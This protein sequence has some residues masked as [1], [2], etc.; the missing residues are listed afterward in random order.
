MACL[1]AV[2]TC[3]RTP[4]E[5]QAAPA[6][7]SEPPE[8]QKEAPVGPKQVSV[9]TEPPPRRQHDDGSLQNSCITGL[10]ETAGDMVIP[11]R[12]A[13]VT[14]NEGEHTLGKTVSD[15]NGRFVWCIDSSRMGSER[16]LTITVAKDPFTPV[17]QKRKVESGKHLE[18][19]FSL[20]AAGLTD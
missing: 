15:D 10:V 7:S 14:V 18:L 5:P 13:Q 4:K 17:T 1:L 6:E 11:I 19:H 12:H 8:A 9:H 2:S 3:A 20:R 16:H